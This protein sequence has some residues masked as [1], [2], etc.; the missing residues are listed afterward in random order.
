MTP[1]QRESALSLRYFRA[2]IPR[3]RVQYNMVRVWSWIMAFAYGTLRNFRR[4]VESSQPDLIFY[5]PLAPWS[6]A[7]PG[8]RRLPRHPHLPDI[9]FILCRLITTEWDKRRFRFTLCHAQLMEGRCEPTA[10]VGSGPNISVFVDKVGVAE[11]S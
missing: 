5:I 4:P 6:P 2:W 8:S 11:L 3:N 1:G 10:R 7:T 9:P